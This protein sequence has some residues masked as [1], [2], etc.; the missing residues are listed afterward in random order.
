V[1]GWGGVLF[2]RRWQGM[3]RWIAAPLL[4]VTALLMVALASQ[5]F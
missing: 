5:R 4:V 3:A 2:R 1:V